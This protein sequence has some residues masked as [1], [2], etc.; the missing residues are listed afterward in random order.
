MKEVLIII[1][2]AIVSIMS[3][4]WIFTRVLRIAKLNHIMDNPNVR[5]IQSEPVPVM[6]GIAVFFGLASGLLT[7][8]A[9]SSIGSQPIAAIYSGIGTVIIAAAILLYIGALDDIFDLSPLF[10]LFAQIMVMGG[11]DFQQWN[12]H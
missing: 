11:G 2:S 7:Y 5:K 10:R 8:G 4:S 3:V 9:F 12:E 6:G 1:L